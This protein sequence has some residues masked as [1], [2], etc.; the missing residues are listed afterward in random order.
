MPG[1][2]GSDLQLATGGARGAR[3]PPYSST[4]VRMRAGQHE[5]IKAQSLSEWAGYKI[6]LSCSL[7]YSATGST[8]RWEGGTQC[9]VNRQMRSFF[10]LSNLPGNV[11]SNLEMNFAFLQP[12][13][14]VPTHAESHQLGAP[15]GR[16]QP[17]VMH[18]EPRQISLHQDLHRNSAA[19]SRQGAPDNRGSRI[20]G[21][22]KQCVAE[23]T[24]KSTTPD[25]GWLLLVTSA[26]GKET[27]R[28][29]SF[30]ENGRGDVE[31]NLY[32]RGMPV[33]ADLPPSRACPARLLPSFPS[34][35]FTDR[36]ARLST[37]TPAMEADGL[38]S[39]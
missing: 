1:V 38:S 9:H 14:G 33:N 28:S 20:C 25:I 15:G 19:R 13:M 37:T 16:N 32:L 7:L 12:R 22:K 17:R 34:A 21:K 24:Y 11:Q 3:Y 39:E 29:E 23:R 6:F 26:K 36:P 8:G 27:K 35:Q 31:L 2:G 10:H 4:S 18:Y 5:S 30:T